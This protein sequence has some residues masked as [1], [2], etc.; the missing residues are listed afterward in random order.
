M[1][2][3]SYMHKYAKIVLA[4]WLRK[5]IKIGE[6]YKGFPSVDM[7]SLGIF[8]NNRGTKPMWN[9]WL[10]YPVCQYQNKVIGLD[11]QWK[12]YLD[13]NKLKVNSRHNIPTRY[14]VSK[15][16][17]T[18]LYFFDVAIVD[19]EGIKAVF[20]VRHKHDMT[21]DKI[22][23]LEKYKIPYYEIDATWIMSRVKPPFVLEC[24]QFN[25]MNQK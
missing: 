25:T 12:K 5:K 22:A 6:K 21:P 24:V 3:E 17:I 7:T 11:G 14:E 2:C 13:Q 4:S 18:G 23:W 16:D 9:V 10:E 19:E 20:E 8:P 1:S 15:M